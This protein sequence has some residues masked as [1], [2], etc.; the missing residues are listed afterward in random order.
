MAEP[1]FEM[2]LPSCLRMIARQ[3]LPIVIVSF[4][5][6]YIQKTFK[7]SGRTLQLGRIS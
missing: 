4:S 5:Y 2:D 1:V 3:F 6:A 7:G